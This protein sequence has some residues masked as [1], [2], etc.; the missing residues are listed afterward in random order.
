MR[1][2]WV[3]L[4]V[5]VLVGCGTDTRRD[6]G[7]HIV[8]TTNI[9]GDV[10]SNLVG[11]SADVTVLMKRN[12]DPHSF[13][14][15]AQQADAVSRAELIV[16]NGLGLEEGVQ[17]HVDAA[18][19]RGVATLAVGD[20]ID[21]ISFSGGDTENAPDPHFWMDPERMIAAVDVIEAAL[22]ERLPGAT[23]IP[24]NAQAYREQ[25]RELSD[26]MTQRF[27]EI[28]EDRRAL[29][30]NHHVLGYLARRYGL[31]V[32]GAVVPS[33]TTLASPAPSDLEALSAAIRQTGVKTI[34]VDTSQPDRLARAL[35]SQS[36]VDVDVVSL[37]SE[38]LDEPGTA[39]GTYLDMMTANT[40][41][42]IAG[43]SGN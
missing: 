42:I 15:S 22:V 32:V 36:G 14:L 3:A 1:F 20:R 23:R 2:C 27:S 21:A 25:L 18:A 10:V 16:Y 38:S 17:H 4:L 37:Y 26:L 39:A 34:F 35:A 8:V 30:T 41:T 6:G 40:D 28:P 43:L 31:T 5:L 9:L 24:A 19:G 29:V 7:E 33:G 13:E 11:E 12:A